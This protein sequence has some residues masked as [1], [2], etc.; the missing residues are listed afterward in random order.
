MVYLFGED[1]AAEVRQQVTV[2]PWPG[3]G[4]RRKPVLSWFLLF[5]LN[6]SVTPY[7]RQ[8][9]LTFGL[10]LSS[11]SLL[12]HNV[13]RCLLCNFKSSQVDEED[14]PSNPRV[15]PIFVSGPVEPAMQTGPQN[16]LLREVCPYKVKR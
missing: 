4:K 15:L 2:H 7:C 14:E 12:T 10:G 11:H 1:T 6:G 16:Q 13:Q 9:Q 5:P 8:Y 3:I